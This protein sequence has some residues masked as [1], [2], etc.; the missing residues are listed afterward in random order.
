MT[1]LNKHRG[2]ERNRGAQPP[3][4]GEPPLVPFHANSRYVPGDEPARDLSLALMQ[5]A[6]GT[7]PGPQ[8]DYLARLT[9][10]RLR[11]YT[12]LEHDPPGG[13]TLGAALRLSGEHSEKK[14]GSPPNISKPSILTAVLPK[15]IS[16]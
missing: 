1:L 3:K 6:G 7:A 14:G 10:P 11:N 5:L 9:V 8:R 4:P 12:K 2:T 15:L 13:L 16:K